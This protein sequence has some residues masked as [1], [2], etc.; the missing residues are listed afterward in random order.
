MADIPK[1]VTEV[2]D[3]LKTEMPSVLGGDLVGIYLYGSLTQ[4]AFNS[5][6]SDID[7]VI[8]TR[9]EITERQFGDL[10]DWFACSTKVNPWTTRLQASILTRDEILK[11]DS[12]GCLYQFGKLTRSGSDGNPIIWLNILDSGVTL[13]G[14]SPQDFVP[15]IKPPDIFEALK[16]EVNYL[17]DEFENPESEWSDR[18]KYRAYAVLTVCRILFTHAKGKVAS[19]PR[20]AIWA[21]RKFPAEFHAAIQ[22]ALTAET[23]DD[24]GHIAIETI[25]A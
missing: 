15:E 25:I 10:E 24:I 6:R 14:E 17:R 11:M 16:R 9:S 19:K 4:N 7:C 21:C 18:P 2:L 8:V 12:S 3:V 1:Q 22:Q 23:D 20:A 5:G 13:C